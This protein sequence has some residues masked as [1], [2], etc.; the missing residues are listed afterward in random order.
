MDSRSLYWRSLAQTPHWAFHRGRFAGAQVLMWCSWHWGRLV[1][2]G[3]STRFG[4][5]MPA[6]APR[7][8]L[9]RYAHSRVPRRDLD[10][11][12]KTTS[13]TPSLGLRRSISSEAARRFDGCDLV[14]VELDDG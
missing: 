5:P 1:A 12:C 7:D 2:P 3:E 4:K 9:V 13:E 10:N 14:E 6:T 11:G 8:T